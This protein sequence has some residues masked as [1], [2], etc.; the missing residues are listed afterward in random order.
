MALS[1]DSLKL[2]VAEGLKKIFKEQSAK[3]TEE[4]AEQEN[5]NVVIDNICE[6]MATVFSDAVDSYVRS[7]DIFVGE[8][9]VVVV[10]PEGVCSVT[11]AAP[12]K[13]V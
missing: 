9:N 1:K 4:G 2:Q 11:P 10:S 7:G 12:A 6:R 5:P 13:I 8:S 3:A